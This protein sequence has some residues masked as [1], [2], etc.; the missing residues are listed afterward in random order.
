MSW[1]RVSFPSL[2]FLQGKVLTLIRR[3]TEDELPLKLQVFQGILDSHSLRQY[4]GFPGGRVVKNP[5]V[6]A[7]EAGDW[8]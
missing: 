4:L 3:P 5:P 1:G 2:F 6:N 7:G 8:V